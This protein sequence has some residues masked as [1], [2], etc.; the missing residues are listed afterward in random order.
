M[1]GYQIIYKGD[2]KFLV[3]KGHNYKLFL[4]KSNLVRNMFYTNYKNIPVEL[5]ENKYVVAGGNK[6]LYITLKQFCNS[7]S[8]INN[9]LDKLHRLVDYMPTEYF[10]VFE[11]HHDI[12]DKKEVLYS[13]RYQ[14]STM[15]WY[16][17]SDK[18]W[19]NL[20]SMFMDSFITDNFSDEE[21]TMGC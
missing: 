4:D 21:D 7:Y 10:G 16:S 15:P 12:N 9:K 17:N 11:L 6:G 19:Y 3:D 8:Y 1:N 18:Y 14:L 5:D 2:N 13:K 20:L